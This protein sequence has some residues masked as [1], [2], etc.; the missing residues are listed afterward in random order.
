MRFAF[1]EF[2]LDTDARELYRGTEAVRLSPKALRLLELLVDAR[3]RAL[4][5]DELMGE[6]WPDTFVV[7]ANLSNLIGELRAALGD[8]ARQPRFIRTVQRFGYA[9]VD[10]PPRA[11][12]ARRWLVTWPEGRLELTEGT[13]VVGRG[14]GDVQL[15]PRSVSRA[16]ARLSVAA[17]RL[18]Y[19][20]LN[21]KNGSFR[22]G[23]RLRGAV[24][25]RNG[26]VITVGTVALTFRRIRDDSTETIERNALV[27]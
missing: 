7:E 27:R 16:H 3:P 21:S 25:V 2:V 26:D 12:T 18:T 4:A 1:G 22:D 15:V 13:H 23:Q 8:C 5:K 20:D 17:D 6:L 11:G 9:F 14:E 19:E 10:A 24:E